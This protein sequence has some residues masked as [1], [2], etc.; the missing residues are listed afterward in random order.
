MSRSD[1]CPKSS[2]AAQTDEIDITDEVETWLLAHIPASPP[3]T[4]V[5]NDFKLNN[6]MLA[7]DDPR[8][9][10]AIFAWEMCTIGDPLTDLGSTMAYWT[11]SGEGETGLTSITTFP[12]FMT[13]REFINCYAQKSGRD[14]SNIDYYLTFAFYKVGVILQQIYYRWKQGGAQDARFGKL[15]VGVRNLMHQAY[16]AMRR[17]LL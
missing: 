5:H 12:G 16:R 13:R 1:C 6:M 10:T 4:I 11:E 2:V 15:D 3:P 7:A 9:A 14:V 8:H 17:E